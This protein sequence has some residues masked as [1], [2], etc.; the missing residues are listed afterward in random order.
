MFLNTNC[1]DWLKEIF[2]NR[3]CPRCA[4]TMGEEAM[5]RVNHSFCEVKR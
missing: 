5:Y 3:R 2:V 4:Q 1:P